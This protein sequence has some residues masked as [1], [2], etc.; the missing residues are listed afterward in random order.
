MKIL[1]LCLFICLSITG[2]AQSV[3]HGPIVGGVT[4]SSARIFV[5]TDAATAFTIELSSSS[6]FT[7]I[8]ASA[9]GN[10]DPALDNTAI[11]EM[12]GL[13]SNKKYYARITING[14]QS[15]DVARFETFYPQ[16]AAP[17]Q[18][19]LTGAGIKG[20]TDTD[21]AIFVR[22]AGENAKAFIQ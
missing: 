1:S 8:A 12:D 22:A 3:T 9:N 7:T 19:F 13:I 16:G 20:L 5:R 14:S 4:D 11:I 21:S 15:G 2:V 17:H 10:T 18:V 6:S